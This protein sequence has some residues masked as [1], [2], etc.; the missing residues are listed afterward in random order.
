MVNTSEDSVTQS[1]T[2]S[3]V[4]HSIAFVWIKSKHAMNRQ[5]TTDT[6][7]FF[8]ILRSLHLTDN[9]MKLTKQMK[10]RNDPEKDKFNYSYAKHDSPTE[11]FTVEITVL[12][13]HILTLKQ[14]I[15]KKH[16]PF[17]RKKLQVV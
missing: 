3:W 6:E 11:H 10:N 7:T 5:N 4:L 15:P 17:W 2:Q 16:K 9:K 12:F 8:R 13:R 14:Y 1:F